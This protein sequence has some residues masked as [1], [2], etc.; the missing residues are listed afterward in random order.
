LTVDHDTR[1]YWEMNDRTSLVLTLPDQAG[2]LQKALNVFTENHLNLTR[3]VSRPPKMID[4]DK[5]VDVLADFEGKST[6]PKVENAIKQLRKLSFKVTTV[7]TPE[8]P[9]FPTQ[10][11]DFDHIGKR[12]LSSGDGIQEVDHPGFNDLEYRK[13]RQMITTSALS[14]KMSDPKIL[15]VKY[16]DQEKSVWKFCYPKLKDLFKT[17]AC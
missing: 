1:D 2:A 11:D 8:V 15:D 16:T 4:I 3:I 9:W 5:S 6:D 7:G 17:N 14:Y 13:R 12:V 10:I